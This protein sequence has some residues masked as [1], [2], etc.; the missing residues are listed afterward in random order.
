MFADAMFPILIEIL[1][2]LKFS[3]YNEVIKNVVLAFFQRHYE[4]VTQV[5]FFSLRF[6]LLLLKYFAFRLHKRKTKYTLTNHR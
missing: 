4:I 1:L 3:S 2:S 6:Y 5:L